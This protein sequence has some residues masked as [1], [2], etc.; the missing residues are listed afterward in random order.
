MLGVKKLGKTSE[1]TLSGTIRL[2][3]V[4][5]GL[6][7]LEERIAKNFDKMEVLITQ[8]ETESKASLNKIWQVLDEL[9]SDHRLNTY[10]IDKLER[11][12]GTKSPV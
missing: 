4:S 9:K 2:E 10:R 5:A 6:E 8:R 12:G 11:N 1:G 7:Q 3:H